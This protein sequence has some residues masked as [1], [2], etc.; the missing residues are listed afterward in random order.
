MVGRL[1]ERHFQLVLERSFLRANRDV[2][3]AQMVARQAACIVFSRAE[4]VDAFRGRA[5]LFGRRTVATARASATTTTATAETAEATPSTSLIVRV[6]GL[7]D[8]ILDAEFLL[9]APA[10][11][12]P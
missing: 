6:A 2:E 4:D 9:R 3:A 7:D 8:G 5:R 12:E 11:I 1:G 10:G